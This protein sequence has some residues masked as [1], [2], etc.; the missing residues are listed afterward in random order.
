MF[1]E[2]SREAFFTYR[3]LTLRDLSHFLHYQK[4]TVLIPVFQEVSIRVMNLETPNLL[5]TV[6]LRKKLDYVRS[7]A[8]KIASI[9]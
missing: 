8:F 3:T 9:Y 6:E 1:L 5:E 4:K 2:R 7:V